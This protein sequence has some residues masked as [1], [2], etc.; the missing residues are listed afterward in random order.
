MGGRGNAERAIAGPLPRPL[1]FY[2][3]GPQGCVMPQETSNPLADA[4]FQDKVRQARDMSPEN[5]FMA[6]A[7]LFDLACEIARAGIRSQCPDLDDAGVERALGER[8]D[9]ARRLER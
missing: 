4:L 2:D 1:R 7:E 9:L 5:K 6:G 8:L 3:L